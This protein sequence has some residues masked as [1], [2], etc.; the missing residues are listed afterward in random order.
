MNM[1][2]HFFRWCPLSLTIKLD[3]NISKVIYW[4]DTWK[5]YSKEDKRMVRNID[6]STRIVLETVDSQDT[7]KKYSKEDKG[8]I[9]NI[10]DSTRI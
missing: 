4:Q 5:K 3:F 10:D 7:Y 1:F 9:R 6:E 2:I 8:M